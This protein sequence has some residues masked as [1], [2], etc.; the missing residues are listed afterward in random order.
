MLY[1]IIIVFFG[2][3]L[4]LF[5]SAKSVDRNFSIFVDEFDQRLSDDDLS[6]LDWARRATMHDEETTHAGAPAAEVERE[7][8]LF[9]GRWLRMRGG[10]KP[11]KPPKIDRLSKFKRLQFIGEAS[12]PQKV[13]AG[14]SKN[15][16]IDLH[17]AEK[18]VDAGQSPIQ[19]RESNDGLSLTLVIPANLGK[20]D[21]LEFEL[22]A[23][24]FVIGGEAK[25]RQQL[26][27]SHLHYQWNCYFPNSGSHSFIIVARVAN[28]HDAAEIDR[29]ERGIRVV[30][31]DHLTQRQV[32]ILATL[33]G[34]ASGGLAVAKVLKELHVW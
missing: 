24:G 23:A 18:L 8:R 30:K 12:I 9:R 20:K 17:P 13:Y 34:L 3:F 29:I 25:Q 31:L 16:K 14:D 7:P 6:E 22:V 4:W 1:V 10:G 26:D 2:I 21:H 5:K 15:L 33:A 27:A 32:W 19:V 28:A 11:R